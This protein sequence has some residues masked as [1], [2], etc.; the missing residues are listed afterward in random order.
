ML[1]SWIILSLTLSN[2]ST[3]RVHLNDFLRKV[4][5]SIENKLLKFLLTT[6]EYPLI[7][8]FQRCIVMMQFYFYFKKVKHD[9]SLPRA[10]AEIRMS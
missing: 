1:T 4:S 7:K 8:Y 9:Y 10:D 6:L 5:F 3:L 2:I